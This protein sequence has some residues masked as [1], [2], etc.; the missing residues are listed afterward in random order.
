MLI[1][2]MRRNSRKR[3]RRRKKRV[4][5]GCPYKYANKIMIEVTDRLIDLI[6]D[7]M[8]RKSLSVFV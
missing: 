1:Y 8:S 2:V 7:R 4:Q 6:V 5:S 3:R